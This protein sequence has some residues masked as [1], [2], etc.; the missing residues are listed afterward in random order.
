MFEKVDYSADQWLMKNMDPLND[1]I[2]ALLQQSSDAFTREIWKD[3]KYGDLL[4]DPIA[5]FFVAVF[6]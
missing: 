4:V 2:V 1:N 6:C 5:G 3:G